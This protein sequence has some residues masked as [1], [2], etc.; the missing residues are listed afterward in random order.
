[1]I[2]L[3]P[4]YNYIGKL[5]WLTVTKTLIYLDVT[6]ITDVKGFVLQALSAG[7]QAEQIFELINLPFK[8]EASAQKNG[9]VVFSG[10]F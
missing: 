4:A 10:T 6:L 2:R 5:K 8:K 3:Y 1:M 7:Y 9:V